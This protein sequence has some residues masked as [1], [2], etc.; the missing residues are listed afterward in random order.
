M[1]KRDMG[2][3]AASSALASFLCCI[4]ARICTLVGAMA[5]YVAKSNI[6]SAAI[7]VT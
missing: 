6:K 1:I 5:H 7:L 3:A 2:M 4:A